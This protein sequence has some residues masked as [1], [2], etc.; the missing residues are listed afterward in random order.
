MILY[1][2]SLTRWTCTSLSAFFNNWSNLLK[3]PS[4]KV[5]L[6]MWT[7]VQSHGQQYSYIN[8]S[9]VTRTT[10]LLHGQQYSHTDNSTV[11]RTTVQLHV[12]Q[13]SI[14]ILAVTQTYSVFGF[15]HGLVEIVTNLSHQCDKTEK[16]VC[17]CI[18]WIK[19]KQIYSDHTTCETMHV[20]YTV[21]L[22]M[23]EQLP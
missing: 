5:T 19:Y 9:T 3:V 15:V 12:Q 22:Q 23:S 2:R 1:I 18:F 11:T 10:G 8:N 16:C 20:L 13:Y 21:E 14:Q 7:T 6:V 17:F 4:K